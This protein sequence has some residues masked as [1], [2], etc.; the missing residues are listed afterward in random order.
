MR[1]PKIPGLG[2]KSLGGALGGA[3]HKFGTLSSGKKA[4]VV[5]GA[6]AVGGLAALA[7]NKWRK[8][9]VGAFVHDNITHP[10]AG[11]NA[12]ALRRELE[13][14]SS[15]DVWPNQDEACAQKELKCF[16]NPKAFLRY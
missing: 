6:A 12:R 1:I 5:G 9:K 3:A 8:S 15:G 14:T 7:W 10:E 13:D 2:T 16:H 11:A 4:A